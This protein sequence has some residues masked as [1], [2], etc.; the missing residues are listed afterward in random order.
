MLDSDLAELYQVTTK[1]L[2]QAVQRNLKRFPDD[3]L[4]KLRLS[5][6]TALKSQIVTSKVGR[7]GARKSSN[8]FT[9]LGVAMLSSV[10][11]S[12][13]AVQMNVYIM[14]AFVLLRHTLSTNADLAK[15]IGDIEKKQKDQ[16]EHLVAISSVLKRLMSEGASQ[17][18]AIGFVAE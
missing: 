7:G 14:R 10:L 8:A 5:E 4:I 9:E 11:K 1:A 12:D 3:F 15:K 6:A 18:D 13:R 2:N 17:K 16:G